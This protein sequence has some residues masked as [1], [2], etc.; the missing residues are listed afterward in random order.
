MQYSKALIDLYASGH[1]NTIG[2]P[3][4]YEHDFLLEANAFNL[5]LGTPEDTYQAVFLDTPRIGEQ[6]YHLPGKVHF[7]I[8]D[9]SIFEIAEVPYTYVD[10]GLGGGGLG[11]PSVKYYLVPEKG[12]NN[13][14]HVQL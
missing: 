10:N 9:P 2:I 3:T 11:Y 12:R 14:F 5:D 6:G 4:D 1:T 7:E 13:Y 8:K